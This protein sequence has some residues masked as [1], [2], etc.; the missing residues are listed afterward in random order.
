SQFVSALLLSGARYEQGV[1]VLH[2]G[3]PMPSLPHIEMTIEMLRAAGVEVHHS[4]PTRWSIAP[5]VSRPRDWRIEPD[6][7]NAAAFLAAAA[8]TNGTIT[9]PDWPLATTQPGDAMR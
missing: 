5:G 7:S 4:E 3:K 9:V 1:T 2:D 6:L 8:V